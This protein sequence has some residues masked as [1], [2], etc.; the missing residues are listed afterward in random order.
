MHIVEILIVI[1][2]IVK[3]FNY[4]NISNLI[5]MSKIIQKQYDFT[6]YKSNTYIDK[7]ISNKLFTIINEFN[8]ESLLDYSITNNISLDVVDDDNNG[9][10]LIHFVINNK[11][12]SEESKLNIIKFLVK[13]NVHP[14]KPNKYNQTPLHIACSLQLLKIIEY[15]LSINVDPNFQDN[16]DQTPLHLFLLGNIIDKKNNINNSIDIIYDDDNVD[17]NNIDDEI[18]KL[19]RYIWEEINKWIKENN[20]PILYTI[21]Q[22]ILNFVS[23]SDIINEKINTLKETIENINTSNFLKYDKSN[24]IIEIINII[25][26]KIKDIITKKITLDINVLEIHQ[27]NSKS[28]VPIEISDYGLIKNSNIKKEIKQSIQNSYINITDLFNNMTIE[29]IQK[30]YRKSILNEVLSYMHYNHYITKVL[31][32][33]PR[34]PPAPPPPP[35][36]NIFINNNID[37]QIR[38]KLAYDNAS[39]ILDFNNFNYVGSARNIIIIYKIKTNKIGNWDYSINNYDININYGNIYIDYEAIMTINDNNEL[40]FKILFSIFD[41]FVNLNDGYLDGYYNYFRTFMNRIIIDDNNLNQFDEYHR[42]LTRIL[43]FSNPNYGR[44]FIFFIIIIIKIINNHNFEKILLLIDFMENNHRYNANFPKKW[45]DIYYK[46]NK[47]KLFNISSFVFNMWNDFY[48]TFIC[49]IDRSDKLHSVVPVNLL[50][51]IIGLNNLTNIQKSILSAFKPHLIP[52][53]ILT[54]IPN[55][56][57]TYDD[58]DNNINN[59]NNH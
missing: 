52:H 13:N 21:K 4:K 3:I 7:K 48:G 46:Y 55:F 36:H 56:T 22:T 59:T 38:Y 6:V 30:N 34:P 31:P 42:L 41:I 15:L 12:K 43:I 49:Y 37:Q 40:V 20:L 18:F 51:L 29:V 11:I 58:L 14:D 35:R 53:I 28:W 10:N 19:K 54:N 16:F 57:I 47:N 1:I 17:N 23:N 2:H 39:S 45:I 44:H 24:K 5:I 50:M 8:I 9:D 27:K 25:K 26:T 32:N 33:L